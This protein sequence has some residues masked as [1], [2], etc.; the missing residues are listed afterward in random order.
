MLVP[1]RRTDMDTGVTPINDKLMIDILDRGIQK[2]RAG[3]ILPDDDF[4]E[5]GIR[6]RKCRVLA[7]GPEAK[8]EGIGVGDLIMVDHGNWTRG[9]DLKL[10]D[11]TTK[12]V[13][14]TNVESVLMVIEE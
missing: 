11:G 2:S 8:R 1:T 13:W 4:S 12:K 6:V 9:I 5:R 14:F 10:P 3:I 7:I